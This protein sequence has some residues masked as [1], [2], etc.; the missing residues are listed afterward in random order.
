MS[1]LS[2]K[3]PSYSAEVEQLQNN[4]LALGFSVSIDGFFGAETQQAVKDFQYTWGNL[5]IDG[6]VGPMTAAAID[7][8]VNLL[9]DGQWNAAL[10]PMQIPTTTPTGEE[11]PS[12]ARYMVAYKTPTSTGASK[13]IQVASI[14]KSIDWKW[15]LLGLGASI[16]IF[17]MMRGRKK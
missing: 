5:T 16:L 6:I 3:S 15:I 17:R 12:E 9:L 4:L 1:T 7:S 10:D 13:T 8:A 14:L 2:I 11:W